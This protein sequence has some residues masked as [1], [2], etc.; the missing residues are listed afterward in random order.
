M[1]ETATQNKSRKKI[2]EAATE[3]G[4]N[5]TIC[6]HFVRLL[7]DLDDSLRKN[8]CTSKLARDAGLQG[9]SIKAAKQKALDYLKS[10]Y[11]DRLFNPFHFLLGKA[12]DR[13]T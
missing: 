1:L 4:Y 9:L 11:Q 12:F 3:E 6:M 13:R 7:Q 2:K 8:D 5:D 10:T